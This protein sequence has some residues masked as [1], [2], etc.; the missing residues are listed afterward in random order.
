MRIQIVIGQTYGR[1]TVEAGSD[2]RG[3]EWYY[4]CL[5]A[6]GTRSM[7]RKSVLLRDKSGCA[8]CAPRLLSRLSRAVEK[9]LVW[10]RH[11]RRAAAVE[12]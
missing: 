9:F 4:A 8:A 11:A 7:V 1:W 3:N 6:C 12:R 5:C 2:L 10:R